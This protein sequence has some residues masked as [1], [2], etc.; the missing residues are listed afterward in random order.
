MFFFKKNPK[1]SETQS[2][3][4]FK[5]IYYTHVYNTFKNKILL[6]YNLVFAKIKLDFRGIS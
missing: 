1:P 3:R 5:K 2:L 6:E 4:L